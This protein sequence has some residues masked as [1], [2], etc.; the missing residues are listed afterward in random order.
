MLAI[1]AEAPV[2]PPAAA[3][4][5]PSTVKASDAPR[6][7]G[8]KITPATAATPPT[9]PVAPPVMPAILVPLETLDRIKLLN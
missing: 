1:A 6:V 5:T 2:T 3:T 7:T 9:A 4:P 8:A